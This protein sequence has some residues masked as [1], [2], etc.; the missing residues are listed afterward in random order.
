MAAPIDSTPLTFYADGAGQFKAYIAVL[1]DGSV[2]WPNKPPPDSPHL[3]RYEVLG[4]VAYG[5]E[6]LRVVYVEGDIEAVAVVAC[7]KEGCN[8]QLYAGGGE[9]ALDGGCL[10]YRKPGLEAKIAEWPPH[11]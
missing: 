10:W 5:Q 2:V 3:R 7:K 1:S 8:W 6:V 9:L 11:A 4:E